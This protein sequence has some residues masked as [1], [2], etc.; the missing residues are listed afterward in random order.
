[1]VCC[2]VRAGTCWVFLNS[3]GTSQA[4][5]IQ[6]HKRTEAMHRPHS[7]TE[8]GLKQ[9][10][11][12]TSA[13]TPKSCFTGPAAH[14]PASCT[15]H[16]HLPLAARDWPAN[17]SPPSQTVQTDRGTRQT[18]ADTGTEAAVNRAVPN[19]DRLQRLGAVKAP[20]CRTCSI[21]VCSAHAASLT[22]K[23]IQNACSF[24]WPAGSFMRVLT[25]S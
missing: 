16:S 5:P 24:G 19:R 3:S 14:C 21:S 20:A 23:F 9:L 11:N 8:P 13:V 6:F 12:Q 4:Q 17:A 1:M 15:A 18:Q 7:V 25:A 10:L 22:S 2:A